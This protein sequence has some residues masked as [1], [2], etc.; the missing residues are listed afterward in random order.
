[1]QTDPEALAILEDGGV[2][3]S[4]LAERLD[5][6]APKV[7]KLIGCRVVSVDPNDPIAVS[8][9][10]A[11]IKDR[12]DSWAKLDKKGGGDGTP[13][14]TVLRIS[15][16]ERYLRLRYGTVLPDDDAGHDDLVILLNHVAHNRTDP[17]GKMLGFIRHLAPWMAPDK[18]EALV[19]MILE[20]PRKYTQKRLGYLLRLTDAERRQLSIT[21]IRAFDATTESMAEDAKRKD[22]EDQ[23]ARRDEK[24]SGRP[25]GRPASAT[26]RRRKGAIT[27]SEWLAANTASQ[28]RPWVALGMKRSWYYELKKRGEPDRTGPAQNTSEALEEESY[29]PDGIPVP[30]VQSVAPAFERGP[31]EAA[32]RHRRA[33]SSSALTP[34][35]LMG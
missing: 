21:T 25:R 9:A 14:I 11:A 19:A 10:R 17:G 3:L 30:P 13:V 22:R 6:I 16:L 4:D 35:L 7:G 2:N 28:V 23:K 26:G 31:P 5:F 32:P 8:K 27:R 1:M 20:K 34:P 15:E 33:R 24:R 12:H 18:T 29:A